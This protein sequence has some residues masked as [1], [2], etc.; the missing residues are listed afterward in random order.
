MKDDFSNRL[1]LALASRNMSSVELARKVGISEARI[2]QYKKGV[3]IAR[4]DAVLKIATALDIDEAWL[5][6]Y[7]VP[8]KRSAKTF[9]AVASEQNIFP[10]NSVTYIGEEEQIQRNQ[11]KQGNFLRERRE[12][13]GLSINDI[14]LTVGVSAGTVSEWE[15]K[16]NFD[17]TQRQIKALAK[18]LDVDTVVITSL[19]IY[20][21]EELPQTFNK[22]TPEVVNV[23]LAKRIP[24]LGEVAAGTPMYID[25][26]ILEWI[27]TDLNG[28]HDY[29]ALR[30][31][32]DS[33]EAARIFDGDTVLIQ[34]T[35]TVENGATAVV[36]V[37][38]E[39]ATLKIFHK[40]GHTI[41]LIPQSYNPANIPQIYDV[42]D[43]QINIFG[44]LI[45]VRRTRR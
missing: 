11:R 21:P 7:D 38:N 24:V 3:H 26:N 40:E 18:I 9:D 27:Y 13:L 36:G 4:P 37:N 20:T 35:D 15:V 42:R 5:M 45:E 12:E 44:E 10:I 33:M 1:K 31:K 30:V 34:K 29:F 6:G 43:T 39:A 14:A 16:S 22:P 17:M 23:N 2:S 8:M 28:G 19:P 25:D 41:T 32:G